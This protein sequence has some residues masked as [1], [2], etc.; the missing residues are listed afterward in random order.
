MLRYCDQNV[1]DDKY[2]ISYG[3]SFGLRNLNKLKYIITGSMQKIQ[4]DLDM[5]IANDIGDENENSYYL[6]ELPEAAHIEPVSNEN[7]RENQR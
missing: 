7:F 5:M 1:D 6:G 3:Y 2:L 4:T